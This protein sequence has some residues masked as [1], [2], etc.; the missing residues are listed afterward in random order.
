MS[1]TQAFERDRYPAGVPCWVD[2]ARRDQNAAADFYG[3][4]FGWR[5][6]EQSPPG[7][8][9]R[10]DAAHAP[11][12]PSP[13]P[14]SSAPRTTPPA[15]ARS[16][17]SPTDCSPVRRPR[18][19]DPHRPDRSADKAHPTTRPRPSA[20]R[21]PSG[22]RPG[23]CRRT[24]CRRGPRRTGAADGSA[25]GCT[26]RR[27]G[28]SRRCRRSRSSGRLPA[29]AG[30]ARGWRCRRSRSVRRCR[31]CSPRRVAHRR[32]RRAPRTRC[33]CRGRCAGAPTG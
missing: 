4:L 11:R 29:R 17:P 5:F 7:P 3:G 6:E 30:S 23:A 9:R 14:A 16:R 27:R 22:S 18:T 24:P 10:Y 13:A 8:S 2:I 32:V 1:E 15:H 21:T 20:G 25:S 19:R 12:T 31:R 28:G 26:P 33:P